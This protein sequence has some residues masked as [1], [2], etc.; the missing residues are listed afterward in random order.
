LL[1]DQVRQRLAGGDAPPGWVGL[2]E[3]SRQLG[4]SKQ[5]VAY[6]VKSGKLN[7]MRTKVGN[8]R[9]WKIDVCSADSPDCAPQSGLFDQMNN[10]NIQES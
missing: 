6:L 7:A 10:E 2:T 4:L 9:C 8:R 3:A 5:R 1:T